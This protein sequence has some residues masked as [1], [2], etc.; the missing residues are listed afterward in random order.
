MCVGS[1]D[2]LEKRAAVSAVEGGGRR[3]FANI[4]KSSLMNIKKAFGSQQ[5]CYK[6]ANQCNVSVC[7][8]KGLSPDIN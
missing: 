1:K 5:L 4:L 7:A 2:M 3:P 6:F 8:G